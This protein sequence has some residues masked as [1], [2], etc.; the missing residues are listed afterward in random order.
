MSSFDQN[1]SYK[2]RVGTRNSLLARA[3]TDLAIDYISCFHPDIEFEVIPIITKGDV[4]TDKPLYDI[5]GKALF[6]KAIED[7]LLK[8]EIDIAVHSAKDVES[9]YPKDDLCFPCVLP[10]EDNRDVFIS[11]NYQIIPSNI[12]SLKNRMKIGSSSVRRQAQIKKLLNGKNIQFYPIRGNVNTRLEKLQNED[13]DGII[14]AAAG[15]KRLNIDLKNMQILS[16]QEMMP[17]ISQGIIVIQS[18]KESVKINKMLKK[19]SDARTDIK[20]KIY[21]AFVETVNGSCITPLAANVIVNDL[22]LEAEF[23]LISNNSDFSHHIKFDG[24]IQDA[25]KIGIGAGCEML[26]YLDRI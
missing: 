9:D 19:I 1:S 7:A 20:F 24:L 10:E 14:L 26:K 25:K 8:N 22:N 11:K 5:G 16:C 15:L 4:I 6:T 3:Q 18:K 12:H 21:R 23:L 13:L 2:I 17:A